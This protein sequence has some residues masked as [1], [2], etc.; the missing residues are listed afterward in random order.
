MNKGDVNM[1]KPEHFEAAKH[2]AWWDG[3][4][5][6]CDINRNPASQIQRTRD[7]IML[8]AFL[9]KEKDCVGLEIGG[10][11]D[12][13]TGGKCSGVQPHGVSDLKY[14]VDMS[15]DGRTLIGIS[16]RSIN[17]IISTHVFEHINQ[18]PILTLKRWYEVLKPGGFIL[19]IM[20]DKR[21]FL[22][23][24]NVTNEF[25]AAMNEMEPD[26]MRKCLADFTEKYDLKFE[27]LLMDTHNNNF[28]FDVLLRKPKE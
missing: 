12:C 26:D 15:L 9:S 8:K 16:D 18:D 17:Y 10:R 28:D 3:G 25:E 1:E 6:V 23:D 13:H 4:K 19:I 20:P 2:E 5:G 21:H 27:E 24:P 11:G 7:F 22:H 14:V